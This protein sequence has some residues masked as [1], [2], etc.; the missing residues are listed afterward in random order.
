M[1]EIKKYIA[2]ELSKVLLNKYNIEMTLEEIILMLEKP[3]DDNMGDIALPCF[4]FAKVLKNSPMNIANQ[5]N[6]NLEIDNRISKCEV[7][8]GYINFYTNS[9][10][11]CKS[12]LENI[13]HKG[14]KY[15]YVNVGKGQ[16]VTID[17]SS[18]NIAKPFHLGHFRTTIIGRTLYNLYNELGYNSI[19]INHLG[20]WGRQFGLVIIGYEMFK[21][22]YD[23]E[24]DPLHILSE[25]YVRINKLAKE[26][27]SIFV[28]ASDNFKK[29]EEGDKELL[30]LWQYFKDVSM[31]EYDRIYK[32]LG[33]KFDSFNGEAFYNDKMDEVVKILDKKGVLV[34]SEGAKVVKLSENE[35]PCIILKSNGSTIYATRDLAAVLY[36]SRTY[37]Y[38]KSIYVTSYEQ[39]HHFKQVFEVSKFLVDEKYTKELVH[40]PYGMVRLKTGKMSSREGTVVYL[41]DLIEEAIAKSKK[42]IEEKGTEVEDID[43]LA[44]QIGIGALIFNDLKHNKIKDIVFDLD[45]VLRF[46]GETGPYIQ[47]TYVRIF[48][49]INKSGI[50]INTIKKVNYIFNEDE[51]KLIKLLD[52]FEDIIFETAENYEP[53]ILVRYIIDVASN[54]STFYN[55]N[56]IL[57]E[58]NNIKEAR[59][60]L[61]NSTGIV[62]KKGLNLLGI[63]TPT[64]M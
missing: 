10:K 8:S 60:L 19:G 27:E 24:K 5:I 14:N 33:C 22:E 16:N 62:I 20:D 43:L 44:K 6:E 61:A 48:S 49:L 38:A 54:F 13:I 7:V 2:K 17:Y 1:E 4:K 51:V 31:K 45:E 32:I 59:L 35:P 34:L 21:D 23:I 57:V 12:I 30:A 53:S 29:L 50:D 26:D 52:M 55:N 63:E 28:K 64:K 42:I 40:V 47:Y 56:S 36:R 3:K 9:E 39:I 18:P 58:D 41:Q 37:D 25:I 15:G 46:D 11:L